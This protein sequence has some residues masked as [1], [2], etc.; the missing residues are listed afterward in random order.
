MPGSPIL[1]VADAT[2]P[3]WTNVT[4]RPPGLDDG[5]DDTQLT[6]A[7]VEE[8]VTNGALNL[9]GGTTV[10]GKAVLTQA[11]SCD[12]GQIL[13]YSLSTASWACG[14]DAVNIGLPA[15]VQAMIEAM[16]LNLQ[17]VSQVNGVDVLNAD[18]AIRIGNLDSSSGIDG[19]S[20]VIDNGVPTWGE[21]SSINECSESRITHS[22]GSFYVSVDC[23][24]YNYILKTEGAT[25]F[26]SS[27]S[28]CGTFYLEYSHNGV[29]SFI[30][31]GASTHVVSRLSRSS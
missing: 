14:D 2:T 3:D 4:N 18:S 28:T 15:E 11:D 1:T 29:H 16:T 22:D 23:G 13:V 24:N 9:D 20:I 10:G 26:W 25:N 12:D 21:S 30:D 5:D 27:N 19:Q 17:N 6:E 31:C 8:M 7:E